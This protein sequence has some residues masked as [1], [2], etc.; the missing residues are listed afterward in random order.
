MVMWRG[1]LWELAVTPS[2]V[3]VRK[4][5]WTD[6]RLD[7]RGSNEVVGVDSVGPDG[8]TIDCEEEDGVSG[9]E[10]DSPEGGGNSVFPILARSEADA[11]W[12]RLCI[13]GRLM[14]ISS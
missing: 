11:D 7:L 2:L 12:R 9:A 6:R 1:T 3:E 14:V 4:F 13:L 8:A 5:G 10:R